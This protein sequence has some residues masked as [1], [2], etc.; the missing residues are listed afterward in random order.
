MRLSTY[1]ADEEDV[2]VF[3]LGHDVEILLGEYVIV[4][5]ESVDG[6]YPPKDIIPTTDRI[7]K[8]VPFGEEVQNGASKS[9]IRFNNHHRNIRELVLYPTEK[10][11]RISIENLKSAGQNRAPPG[12]LFI[13]EAGMRM[14]TGDSACRTFTGIDVDPAPR[15]NDSRMTHLF[16]ETGN[17]R[18]RGSVISFGMVA[19]APNET[20][21]EF[22]QVELAA[23]D[24]ERVL[25]VAIKVPNVK[26]VS[27]AFLKEQPQNVDMHEMVVQNF[28]GVD[29][30]H[31]I[32]KKYGKLEDHPSGNLGDHP[33]GNLAPMGHEFYKLDVGEQRSKQIFQG[34]SR[35]VGKVFIEDETHFDIGLFEEWRQMIPP[36]TIDMHL[37]AICDFYTQE[38]HL[39]SAVLGMTRGRS[40]SIRTVADRVMSNRF[41]SDRSER[42]RRKLHVLRDGQMYVASRRKD[43]EH[44]RV[45]EYNFSAGIGPHPKEGSRGRDRRPRTPPDL[46]TSG[47]TMPTNSPRRRVEMLR[48]TTENE[49]LSSQNKGLKNLLGRVVADPRFKDSLIPAEGDA[50]RKTLKEV[51]DL[52]QALLQSV[53][54]QFEAMGAVAEDKTDVEAE[55][56]G[57]AGATAS[58]T[59][60]ASVD[61]GADAATNSGANAAANTA[62]TMDAGVDIAMN[63]V[64]ID[65]GAGDAMETSAGE[66][67]TDGGAEA[68]SDSSDDDEEGGVRLTPEPVN[69]VQGSLLPDTPS[70][71]RTLDGQYDLE[72]STSSG[73]GSSNKRRQSQVS[74]VSPNSEDSSSGNDDG[75]S[76]SGGGTPDQMPSPKKRRLSPEANSAKAGRSNITKL[77]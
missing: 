12:D 42:L 69:T 32:V 64:S 48:L 20:G 58:A 50:P 29:H 38:I 22:C 3:N 71:P 53:T 60:G 37:K 9:F 49:E 56:G 10:R 51:D 13:D 47:S 76:E 4:Y 52:V 72:P 36:Q 74:R 73:N 66:V 27:S 67:V 26:K 39:I 34:Y 77:T 2:F 11:D 8:I 16:T 21:Y 7:V 68:G 31:F 35:L 41:M 28:L 5:V 45:L 70:E 33:G 57:K 18:Q 54:G 6:R 43:L 75:K 61:T 17:I 24:G 55:R 25:F 23:D 65:A 19:D 1:F 40:S 15:A 14:A 46:S 63:D 30:G 44:Q 62:A 59:A